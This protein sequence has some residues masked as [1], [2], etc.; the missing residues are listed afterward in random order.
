MVF[1]E[2]RADQYTRTVAP[3]PAAASISAT[4]VAGS[5]SETGI[6][7]IAWIVRVY[8][9]KYPAFALHSVMAVAPRGVSVFAGHAS[10]WVALVALLYVP[11]PHT[12][13]ALAPLLFWNSPRSHALHSLSRAP[14]ENVP[15]GHAAQ[16]EGPVEY[17]PL[18]QVVHAAPVVIPLPVEYI[19]SRHAVQLTAS[20]APTADENVPE[21]QLTHA[22]EMSAPT[23]VE[24]RPALHLMHTDTAVAL[25]VTE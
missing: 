2:T 5:Y 25:A 23:P 15:I 13:H 18:E 12:M 17:I 16:A 14:A 24:Y 9:A 8:C 19:P 4:N 21:S 22:L 11:R 10:Q 1:L 7:T 20:A 3:G 6:V